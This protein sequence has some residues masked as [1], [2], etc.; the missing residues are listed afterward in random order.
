MSQPLLLLLLAALLLCF[1]SLDVPTVEAASQPPKRKKRDAT[2]K[3]KKYNEVVDLMADMGRA[4]CG[5]LSRLV[6]RRGFNPKR[7]C[8]LFVECIEDLIGMTDAMVNELDMTQQEMVDSA[9][10]PGHFAQLQMNLK[11]AAKL[12]L[13]KKKPSE[14]YISQELSK[15]MS[16]WILNVATKNKGSGMGSMSREQ[17]KSLRSMGYNVPNQ[18]TDDDA[19]DEEKYILDAADFEWGKAS[20]DSA[21]SPASTTDDEDEDDL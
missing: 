8:D 19:L 11:R 21:S 20:S 1:V 12:V 4:A 18:D 7:R 6:H 2:K 15:D 3:K 10:Q 13:A 9:M 14:K 5:G 16:Q 17:I